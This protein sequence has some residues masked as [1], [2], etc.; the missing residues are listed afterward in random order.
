MPKQI[1]AN[2]VVIEQWFEGLD[3][4]GKLSACL[5]HRLLT[6]DS[7]RLSEIGQRVLEKL[8]DDVIGTEGLT[9]VPDM[10]VREMYLLLQ[11]D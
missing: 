11:G 5:L 1:E 3:F 2:S 6:A 7:K 10:N 9:S 8:H 4:S